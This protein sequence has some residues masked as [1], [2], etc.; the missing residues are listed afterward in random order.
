MTGDVNSTDV[1]MPEPPPSSMNGSRCD[2][3]AHQHSAVA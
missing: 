1:A 3:A 2:E